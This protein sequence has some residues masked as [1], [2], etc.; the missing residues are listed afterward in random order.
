MESKGSYIVDQKEQH[1]DVAAAA[2][3][4]GTKQ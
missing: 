2:K 4:E 1:P 3:S